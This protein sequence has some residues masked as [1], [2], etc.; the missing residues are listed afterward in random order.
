MPAF[1]NYLYVGENNDDFTINVGGAS[2]VSL[3]HG[4]YTFFGF[5]DHFLDIC[6][7]GAGAGG[8]RLGLSNTGHL[9]IDSNGGANFALT[10]TDTALRDLLGF[11]LDLGGAANTYT[12][13]RRVRGS[14]Y[15][16]NAG[17]ATLSTIRDHDPKPGLTAVSQ[18]ESIAGVIRTTIPA[19]RRNRSEFR[20]QFLDNSCRLVSPAGCV[21]TTY[22]GAAATDPGLTEYKHAMDFWHDALTVASQGWCDGRPVEFFETSPTIAIAAAPAAPAS[23]AYTTWVF[24]AAV[25]ENWPA[26]KAR[27]PKTTLYHLA[28]PAREYTAP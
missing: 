4:R 18:T 19:K 15:M 26:P 17:A 5:L 21:G 11:T 2:P 28:L 9:T 13:S 27:E 3:T 14:Y 7:S 23:T 12:G 22:A 24:D 6:Q 25:C 10:W 1:W 16:G 20:L 8:L